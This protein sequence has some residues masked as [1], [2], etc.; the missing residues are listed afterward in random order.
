MTSTSQQSQSDYTQTTIEQYN[1]QQNITFQSNLDLQ[2]THMTHLS[3]NLE[4]D[5]LPSEREISTIQNEIEISDFSKNSDSD[6][7]K[8]VVVIKSRD[9]KPNR[10]EKF[11]LKEKNS[12]MVKTRE[13]GYSKNFSLH[14]EKL[15]SV[16]KGFAMSDFKIN[17]KR[18]GK[19]LSQ[20]EGGKPGNS[21]MLSEKLGSN[22]NFCSF[23]DFKKSEFF[24]VKLKHK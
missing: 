24:F 2:S 18:N 22:K 6:K 5:R 11:L 21:S 8:N 23:D 16:K 14:D 20:A 7:N 15:D 19:R 3:E 10:R 12:A 13:V 4:S 9:R 17:T 1:S